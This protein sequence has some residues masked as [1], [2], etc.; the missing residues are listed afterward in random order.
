MGR[1]AKK[2]FIER[3]ARIPSQLDRYRAFARFSLKTADQSMSD[4][5]L[6][7]DVSA[8]GMRLV[9]RKPSNANVGDEVELEFSLPGSEERLKSSAKVVRR[10]GDF[11]FAVRFL[12]SQTDS[13]DSF[14]RAFTRY[15]DF[16]SRPWWL[17]TLH[18]ISD[19]A[20][21]HKQGLTLS[22]VGLMIASVVGSHI[23]LNSDEYL[24]RDLRPWGKV[25]PK[26]WFLDYV[27][28]FNQAK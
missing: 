4:A 14:K 18:S 20:R 3:S 22:F 27:R 10:A 16:N 7:S 1:Q 19:W 12:A 6:F 5:A 2:D 11:E 8:T 17:R 21:D 23:I 13:G 28:N 25:H 26:E 24:G 9:S 15:S